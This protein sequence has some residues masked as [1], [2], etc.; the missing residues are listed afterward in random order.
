M[1]AENFRTHTI[2][3]IAVINCIDLF[4]HSL[5]VRT[6]FCFAYYAIIHFIF[7][8]VKGFYNF[9][10]IYLCIFLLYLD[11][12]VLYTLLKVSINDFTFAKP[13][14]NA[15]SVIEFSLFRS[16]LYA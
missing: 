9:F 4:A 15:I 1:S 10:N 3:S 8:F 5:K 2:N 11:G 14:F 7:S 6:E 13:L 12:V 16:S